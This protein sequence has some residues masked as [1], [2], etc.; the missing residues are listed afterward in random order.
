MIATQTINT[1]WPVWVSLCL[2]FFVNDVAGQLPQVLWDRTIGGSELLQGDQLYSLAITNDGGYVL[3]GTSRS[4]I[5][6]DKTVNTNGDMDYYIVKLD[7]GGVIQWQHSYG[8]FGND[9]AF[10]VAATSDGGAI[11]GGYSNSGISGSK[12]DT[13]RGFFDYWLLKLDSGGAIQWQKTIGGEQM[14]YL[15]IVQQTIDGGYILGGS[16]A[17]GITGEKLDTNRGGSGGFFPSPDYWVIKLDASGGI[18]W[19]KTIGGTSGDNLESLIQTSDGGYI[20]GGWSASGISGEKTDTFRGGTVIGGGDYWIVKIDDTGKIEWQKT[21]GGDGEERLHAIRQTF[22]GGYI[23]GGW[24]KSGISGEKIE[25]NRGGM[26]YWLVKL[27]DTGQIQWQNAFGGNFDDR[28]AALEQTKDTGYV[29]VGTSISGIS[30]D[31]TEGSK[32]F[33]DY[34]LIQTDKN[35]DLLWQ[36]TIGGNNA[37]GN[38]VWGPG[39]IGSAVRQKAD[40]GY[41]VGGSS[42]SGT[43]GDKTD[44]CRGG[45]DYWVLSICAPL[46]TGITATGNTLISN[47]TNCSYQWLNCSTGTAILGANNAAFTPAGSGSYAVVVSQGGCIDT[48]SCFTITSIENNSKGLDII[49][50]PNPVSTDLFIKNTSSYPIEEVIITD[51]LGK[52]VF[53]QRSNLDLHNSIR[54]DALPSGAYFVSIKTKAVVKTY[55]IQVLK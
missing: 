34:W 25:Y 55:N 2:L 22:D 36:K 28:F 5:S 10:T 33:G 13:L 1:K 42:R 16:S 11:V 50:Y 29:L 27:D 41:I 48:S 7:S 54:T 9:Q 14:D 8:G 23:A 20:L 45:Y 35:G 40:G 44:T 3:V 32:G 24:S 53:C 6:G 37:S 39:E 49:V 21:I 47:A 30:G 15:T 51:I 18:Q 26:D 38:N 43:G 19:Q 12:T 31:K 4:G 52:I 46:D 17:S